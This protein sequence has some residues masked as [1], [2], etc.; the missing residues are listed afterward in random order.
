MLVQAGLCRTCSETTLLVFPR[1]GSYIDSSGLVVL[2][3]FELSLDIQH[4]TV[5]PS[6]QLFSH[7]RT[8]PPIPV[9]ISVY[10]EGGLCFDQGQNTI[11]LEQGLNPEPLDSVTNGQ[12]IAH[13]AYP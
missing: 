12:P 4:E 3:H 6:Q 11:P 2:S 7:V 8:E 13:H 1:D 9:Y 10:T 5:H